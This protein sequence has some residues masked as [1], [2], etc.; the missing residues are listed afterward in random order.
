M[1]TWEEVVCKAKE[2]AETAGRKVNDVADLAKLKLKLTENERAIQATMEA[3][4]RVYYESRHTESELP[5]ETVTEL[6][7][8]I[9]E[10][11]RANADLQAQI[12]NHRG[13]RT[14]DDCGAVN[15]ETARFCTQCGKEL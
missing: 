14:C 2:L 6:M 12:D 4:G 13:K 9:A 7:D 3:L 5:E 1:K 10:L 15:P 8:Q 11:N